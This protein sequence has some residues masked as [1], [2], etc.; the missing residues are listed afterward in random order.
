MAELPAFSPVPFWDVNMQQIDYERNARFVVE[1]V[2][3]YGLWTDIKELLRFYGPDRVKEEAL[4]TVYLKKK[5]L[6]FCCA[7]FDLR[8]EQFKCY[9][10]QQSSPVRWN[11]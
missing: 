11:Y 3:N 6:S 1:K 7:I 2:L 10:R 8:P 9:T 4:Q 5:T